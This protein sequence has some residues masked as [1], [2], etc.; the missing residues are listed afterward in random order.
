M[1]W[2]QRENMSY[3]EKPWS[4]LRK[5]ANIWWGVS[6]WKNNLPFAQDKNIWLRRSHGVLLLS[7]QKWNSVN[8]RLSWKASS[9]EIRFNG[10]REK[11]R[12]NPNTLFLLDPSPI[13]ACLVS[14]LV[15]FMKLL[16][17]TNCVEWVRVLIVSGPLCL[18]QWI[19]LSNNF[20][21][22]RRVINK[23]SMLQRWC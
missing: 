5:V 9:Y 11:R 14:Q 1:L 21:F 17:W 13:I 15:E 3:L 20:L 8:S 19:I 10:K 16:L 2:S 4:L 12:S 23:D 6:V 22:H 7:L 18:W